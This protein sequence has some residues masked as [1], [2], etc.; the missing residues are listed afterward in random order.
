MRP[1]SGK[2][3]VDDHEGELRVERTG[4]GVI[5]LDGYRGGELFLEGESGAVTVSGLLLTEGSG[6]VRSQSGAVLVGVLEQR[7]SIGY[8]AMSLQG[9]VKADAGE[10]SESDPNRVVGRV[11]GGAAR[12]TVQSNKGSIQLRP[13]SELAHELA[14]RSF[15]EDSKGMLIGGLVCMGLGILNEEGWLF[16]IGIG[17]LAYSAWNNGPRALRLWRGELA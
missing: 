7:C 10:V 6:V 3:R 4:D 17:L 11:G 1:G 15:W 12:L 5:Q 14:M 16:L 9:P 2:V 8:E 13:Q